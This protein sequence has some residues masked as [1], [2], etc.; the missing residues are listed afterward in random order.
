VLCWAY[1]WVTAYMPAFA[2]IL[3]YLVVAS[4]ASASEMTYIVSSGAL[5]STHSLTHSQVQG[6]VD[7]TFKV[8]K[9]R[10]QLY[11]G[12]PSRELSPPVF[13]NLKSENVDPKSIRVAAHKG[14]SSF[15]IRVTFRVLKDN[16]VVRLLGRVRGAIKEANGHPV[17]FQDRIERTF[18]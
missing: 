16:K 11:T 7:L 1:F 13:D 2:K 17:F 10:S 15:R 14:D 6:H 9:K 18:K 12:Q 8:W 4:R 3:R 5:N